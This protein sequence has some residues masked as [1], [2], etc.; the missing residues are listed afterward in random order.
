VSVIKVLLLF[1]DG[2]ERL[3]QT[4]EGNGAQFNV[5]LPFLI[6]SVCRKKEGKKRRIKKLYRTIIMKRVSRSK[7]HWESEI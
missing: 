3:H 4:S 5:N 1:A 7:M 2:V 6:Q